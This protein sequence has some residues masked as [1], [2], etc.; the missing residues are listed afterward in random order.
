[1]MAVRPLFLL[2][3][4]AATTLVALFERLWR[5]ALR[6][7]PLEWVVY[8][9]HGRLDRGDPDDRGT[10]HWRL[11]QGP[12]VTSVADLRHELEYLKASPVRGIIVK[13]RDVRCGLAV[14][15]ELRALL[16]DFANSG[17]EVVIHTDQM[18]NREY[19]FASVATRLWMA[20]RGRLELIGFAASSMAAARPLRR[21]GIVFDVIRAGVFKSAGELVGADHVSAEQ[22]HQME[23]L[24]GDLNGLFLTDVARGLGLSKDDVQGLVDRGPYSAA[25]ARTA[26]LID[27][28]AY[29][30]EVRERLGADAQGAP[31]R[32]RIGPFRALLAS[33]ST[34]V[35]S[36]PFRDR[37]PMVAV[38]DMEGII[39]PGKSRAAP[40]TSP[41]AGAES[42]VP[43]LNRLR[44]MKEV[45][46]V[47]LRIDSRGG[48]AAASDLIWRAV[49]RLD[50]TKP[51][52]AYFDDVAASG[53]YYIGAGARRILA[54]PTCIT[55]SI[56][57]FL[58]RPNFAGTLEKLEVDEATVKRGARAAIYRTDHAL[59]DD[60]RAALQES[61]RE[62]YEDFLQV[63]AQG[64]NLPM[65]TVRELAEGRV[66][67]ATRAANLGLVDALGTLEDAIK[68]ANEAAKLEEKARVLWLKASPEGWREMIRAFREGDANELWKSPITDSI[69]ALWAGES[70]L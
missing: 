26:G 35:E 51:V 8:D 19:W 29:A 57:V 22:K 66:Y 25:G 4:N 9:L 55:G 41:V 45:K 30:D 44:L 14:M 69:Q 39:T 62:T 12:R 13:L 38:L 52:I 70:P 2:F 6:P 21:L 34:A 63:V 50:A 53:G 33:Q 1:M 16:E 47:V 65:E 42:L 37:R 61:V 60:E 43:A 24:V 67:V 18:G 20:P 56:G 64:R 48:S 31:R 7:K 11:P 15:R 32:A 59:S 17:K 54:S 40:W 23:D 27:D 46:A 28:V 36:R 68:A 10:W 58:M 49:K 3:F 5:M